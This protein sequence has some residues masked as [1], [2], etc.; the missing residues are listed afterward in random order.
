MKTIN[1]IFAIMLVLTFAINGIMMQSAWAVSD[2]ELENKER[3]I[4]ESELVETV[5][6]EGVKYTYKYFYDDGVKTINITNEND[7]S[8]ETITYN[9]SSTIAYLNGEVLATIT[10]NLGAP[11]VELPDEIMAASVDWVTIG[12]ESVTIS[13][14]A[15]ATARDV[16][17]IIAEAASGLIGMNI[18]TPSVVTAWIGSNVLAALAEAA[19]GGTVYVKTQR[20]YAPPATPRYRYLI[21]FKNRNGKTYGPYIYDQY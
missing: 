3:D 6:F 15:A 12:N 7:N 16:A 4:Y 5:D 18:I 8:V 10:P 14:K 1:K 11:V 2:V 21:S 19:G 9:E 13:W 17:I 20:F